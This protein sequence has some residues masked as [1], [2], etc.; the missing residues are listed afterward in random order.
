MKNGAQK[1]C[2]YCYFKW[3][4]YTCDVTVGGNLGTWALCQT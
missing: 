3:A 4:K 2:T 1:Q